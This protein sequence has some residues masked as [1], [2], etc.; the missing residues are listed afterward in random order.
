[1]HCAATW[2]LVNRLQTARRK[3]PAKCLSNADFDRKAERLPAASCVAKTIATYVWILVVPACL[4]TVMVAMAPGQALGPPAEP[5]KPSTDVNDYRR[6]RLD[7][8]MEVL[9]VHDANT[10][11]AAASVDVSSCMAITS[12]DILHRSSARLFC[13]CMSLQRHVFMTFLVCGACNH[14]DV[15]L[16][17]FS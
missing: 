10:N 4:S 5:V 6:I 15:M 11:K 14:I 17:G 2:H 12:S 1:M 13:T 3:P 9:L 16:W 7:N 8:E